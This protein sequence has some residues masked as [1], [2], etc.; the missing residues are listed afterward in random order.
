MTDDSLSTFKP[1]LQKGA[2]IGVMSPSS[3]VARSDI[4]ASKDSLEKRGY[5][6]FVHPQ[7]YEQNGQSAGTVLQK[8]LALQGLIQRDDIDVIWFA[9]GGNEALPLLESLNFSKIKSVKPVCGFSDNTS[10]LNAMAAH[11]GGIHFHTQVFKNLYKMNNSDLDYML[12]FMSGEKRDYSYTDAQIVQ[13]GK[14]TG[15]LVGGNLSLV[16]YLPSL[17]PQ[18]Y[19]ENSILFLE[20]CNEE[21][22][23]IDRV[24]SFLRVS[25]V[26]AQIN[27]LLIGQFSRLQDNG[28]P[29]GKDLNMITAEHMQGYDVPIIHDLPFG[30]FT[31]SGFMALPIGATITID[32]DSAA[33]K[34]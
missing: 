34:W 21:L 20:D 5:T 19:F 11:V 23:R 10:L 6:V 30:H 22:S 18:D 32:T 28:R 17:L 29:F 9:G 33:M 14:A 12:A 31:D 8:S 16:Q 3:H 13:T 24:L 25:G 7:T 4:E 15:R 1:A 26:L 27:G 2:R